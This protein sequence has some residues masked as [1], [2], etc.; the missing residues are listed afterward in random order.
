MARFLG[1]WFLYWRQNTFFS[2]RTLTVKIYWYIFFCVLCSNFKIWK[3]QTQ[4][5]YKIS[6]ES[7]QTA[8]KCTCQVEGMSNKCFMSL[9]TDL[10]LAY[11]Q[12][13]LIF[14]IENIKVR[15][16]NLHF[17]TILSFR[18]LTLWFVWTI[19]VFTSCTHRN[20]QNRSVIN[21]HP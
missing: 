15:H 21:E 6:I 16:W 3:L 5:M 7:N 4:F 20:F 10:K 1:I 11:N 14:Y 2:Y 13:F 17:N 9:L 18:V 12:R 19:I 8:T